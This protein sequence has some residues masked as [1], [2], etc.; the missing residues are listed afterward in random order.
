MTELT[1]GQEEPHGNTNKLSDYYKGKSLEVQKNKDHPKSYE[2]K[3][4]KTAP[5]LTQE[6]H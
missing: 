3:S 5:S 4:G 2:V 1:R 6:P